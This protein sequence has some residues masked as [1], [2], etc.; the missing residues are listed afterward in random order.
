MREGS[1][2]P[3]E[4]WGGA[5]SEEGT[6]GCQ[7]RKSA[8][9]STPH[10]SCCKFSLTLGLRDGHKVGC[11]ARSKWRQQVTREGLSGWVWGR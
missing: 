7:V 6:P 10:P 8:W 9:K 2:R 11:T 4:V 5:D 1:R 3:G